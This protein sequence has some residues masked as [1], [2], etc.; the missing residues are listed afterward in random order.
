M[1]TLGRVNERKP[2]NKFTAY[3]WCSPKA[4]KCIKNATNQ[5]NQTY[6]SN[7]FFYVSQSTSF[8][9]HI[10]ERCVKSTAKGRA[11]SDCQKDFLP[12]PT[13]FVLYATWTGGIACF[14]LISNPSTA[15]SRLKI[16]LFL[17]ELIEKSP[18]WAHGY[19][20]TRIQYNTMQNTR[21]RIRRGLLRRRIFGRRSIW[22]TRVGWILK[23]MM[24][25][26]AAVSL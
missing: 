23:E 26:F 5:P 18:L 22:W 16:S 1:T 13:P 7:L 6:L 10:R 14:F 9:G 2:M 19:T 20:N 11:E 25:P 3:L 17:R 15:L 12:L 21:E 8:E 24:L 4:P